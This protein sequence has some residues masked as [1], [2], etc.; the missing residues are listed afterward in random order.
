MKVYKHIVE[1]SNNAIL[2]NR[3]IGQ[4]IIT[5]MFASGAVIGHVMSFAELHRRG[6]AGEFPP[7]RDMDPGVLI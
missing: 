2:N 6:Y 3:S 5:S 4:G 1:L 7:S